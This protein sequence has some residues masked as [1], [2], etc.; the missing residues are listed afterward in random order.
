MIDKI[1]DSLDQI[2]EKAG[3]FALV[4][5]PLLGYP[6]ID[7]PDGLIYGDIELISDS[8]DIACKDIDGKPITT[9]C[10]NCI[11]GQESAGLNFQLG[12]NFLKGF[13]QLQQSKFS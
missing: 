5:E 6:T 7:N 2:P 10:Y 9:G 13:C 8:L 4:V 1:T 3:G 11:D 12:E